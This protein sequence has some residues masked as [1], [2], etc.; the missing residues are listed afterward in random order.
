MRLLLQLSLTCSII[1]GC[2]TQNRL[3]PICP[4]CLPCYY[5][6]QWYQHGSRIPDDCNTCGCN[7]GSVMCTLIYCKER[8]CYYKGQWYEHGSVFQDKCNTCWC[9]DGSVGCTNIDCRDKPG[10]CPRPGFGVCWEECSSD[11][12]CPG[13][14]KCCFNGCGHTCEQPNWQ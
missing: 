3:S 6:G 11:H 1:A 10:V 2:S 12:D 13:V 14:Q 9:N 5:M 7:N 4:T 8:R